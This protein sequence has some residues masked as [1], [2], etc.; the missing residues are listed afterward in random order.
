[1]K[2]RPLGFTLLEV[3]VALV[4]TGLVVTLAYATVQGGLDTRDRLDLERNEREALV[5]VRA[6]VRDALRH[7]LPGVPGGDAVFTLTK[8]TTSDG[9]PSD[10][11]TF[12]S[13]GVGQPLG[14]GRAWRVSLSV[15]DSSLRFVAL[16][17]D[18]GELAPIVATAPAV[19]SLEVA[20]VGRGI[21]AAWRADWPDNGVAPQAVS[22][23]LGRPN[24]PPTSLVARLFLERSP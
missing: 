21:L 6:M 12:Y 13:R 10:S 8:R 16:P 14:T 1:M 7:A 15:H 17:Q 19:T 4:I 11:L 9:R 20:A 5:T 23:A 22:L 2:Q 3:A 18:A 24:A